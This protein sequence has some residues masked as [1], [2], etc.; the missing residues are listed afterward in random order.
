[1]ATLRKEA[2]RKRAAERTQPATEDKS[3]EICQYCK[4]RTKGKAIFCSVQSEYKK[5]KDSCDQFTRR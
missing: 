5:R 1:M 4:E 2:R 3:R